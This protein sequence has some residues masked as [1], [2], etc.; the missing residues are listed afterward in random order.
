MHGRDQKC[1]VYSTR[2]RVVYRTTPGRS[3]VAGQMLLK[4]SLHRSHLQHGCNNFNPVSEPYHVAG[5]APA[6]RLGLH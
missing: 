6:A 2:M 4:C 5:A 3:L 1:V